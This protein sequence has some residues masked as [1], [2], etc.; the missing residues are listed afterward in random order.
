ML[1]IDKMNKLVDSSSN[2]EEIIQW[3]YMNRIPVICLPDEEEFESME[4]SIQAFIHTDYYSE[5][6]SDEHKLWD[7]FLDSVYVD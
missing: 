7:K 6:D 3:A 5:N 4:N 2:K 1:N